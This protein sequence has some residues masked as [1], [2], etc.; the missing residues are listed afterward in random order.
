MSEVRYQK[1]S[2]NFLS[3]AYGRDRFL[4][5][6]EKSEYDKMVEEEIDQFTKASLDAGE[7]AQPMD[8][9]MKIRERLYLE[10]VA[11]RPK[12]VKVNR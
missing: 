11:K 1:I 10:I 4:S 8:A 12:T 7:W 5:D 3:C 9:W 6:E 2:D